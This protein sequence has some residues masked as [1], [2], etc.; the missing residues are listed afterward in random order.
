M[1]FQSNKL[2]DAVVVALI[3]GAATSVTAQAQEA[4]N[5]DRISV[6]GSRI[7]S[8]DIET[9]QPVLSLTRADIEK[10]GVTSVADILQRVA[11]NGAALN[12]TFNNGGDGSAGISL[13]NL[14]S[15][16]TLVLVNGRRWTTGLDGSV[17]LNT[18]PTAMIERIDILKDGAS[19][20]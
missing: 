3:A 1:N 16:R 13:R 18:I 14:G 9:S 2:R 6:T 7:K 4:T 8:T 10:Q 11:A 5:L 17:D 20:I 12:R 19:T 15:D